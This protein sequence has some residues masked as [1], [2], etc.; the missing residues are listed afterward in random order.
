MKRQLLLAGLASGLMLLLPSS[1]DSAKPPSEVNAGFR[2]AIVRVE[3]DREKVSAGKKVQIR[4]DWRANVATA[5]EYQLALN[6]VGIGRPPDFSTNMVLRPPA[7]QWAAGE[8]MRLEPVLNF[9]Q[10]LSV[11]C[12]YI[13]AISC[14]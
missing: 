14:G 12:K 6:L 3:L 7:S 10:K 8:V 13:P 4:M 2:P 11:Q 1:A 5:H 9:S